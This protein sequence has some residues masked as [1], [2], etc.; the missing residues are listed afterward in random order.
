LALPLLSDVERRE[1]FE[2]VGITSW[3]E[4]YGEIS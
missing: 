3:N 1:V 4:Y 2:T